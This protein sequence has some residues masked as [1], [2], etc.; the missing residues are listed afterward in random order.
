MQVSEHEKAEKLFEKGA[1]ATDADIRAFA[2]KTL[3]AI[4]E[5]LAEARKLAGVPAAAP[6]VK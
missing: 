5:H 2:E 3:P 1:K 6:A 4:R